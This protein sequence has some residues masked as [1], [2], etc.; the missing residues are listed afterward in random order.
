MSFWKGYFEDIKAV[1]EKKGLLGGL[2]QKVIRPFR[3]VFQLNNI[4]WKMSEKAK[5]PFWKVH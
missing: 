1:F 3:K 5:S 4:F 2:F